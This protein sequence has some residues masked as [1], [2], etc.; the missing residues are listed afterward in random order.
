MKHS[1]V[2]LLVHITNFYF[3]H[4]IKIVYI[5]KMIL[6]LSIFD[7]IFTLFKGYQDFFFIKNITQHVKTAEGC[8]C[9][10]MLFILLTLCLNCVRKLTC[11]VR[12]NVSQFL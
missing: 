6:L 7:S 8:N 12:W 2:G 3:Q 11:H 4:L 5:S 9:S 1:L 10:N